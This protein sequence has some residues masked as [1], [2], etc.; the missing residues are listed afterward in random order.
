MLSIH[1]R[2]HIID[3]TIQGILQTA[4]LEEQKP[5]RTTAL[6]CQENG[7]EKGWICNTSSDAISECLAPTTHVHHKIEWQSVCVACQLPSSAE[8]KPRSE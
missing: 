5:N 1:N 7:R 4:K 3:W 6:I 8:K 2:L